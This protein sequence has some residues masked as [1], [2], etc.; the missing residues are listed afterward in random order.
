M[1]LQCEDLLISLF[2]NISAVLLGW[3]RAHTR[4]ALKPHHGSTWS[5]QPS[6]RGIKDCLTF[7]KEPLIYI[8]TLSDS[9]GK[10]EATEGRESI[11]TSEV[12]PA[13]IWQPMRCMCLLVFELTSTQERRHCSGKGFRGK[14]NSSTF[15]RSPCQQEI[16]E[17][18]YRSE[19]WR[20]RCPI[21]RNI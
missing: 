19:H 5:N 4:A 10:Q 7:E 20:D 1:H 12:K 3:R 18:C 2:R 8:S 13:T 16:E 15:R 14:G 6:L 11:E 9:H 17:N 21:K